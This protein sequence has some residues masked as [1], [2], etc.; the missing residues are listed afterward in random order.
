MAFDPNIV[1]WMF[2][3][4]AEHVKTLTPQYPLYLD[5]YSGTDQAWGEIRFDGPIIENY[6]YSSFR[7]DV[8]VNI[9]VTCFCGSDEYAIYRVAGAF[10][11]ALDNDICCFKYGNG[12]E[13]D[14]SMFV[15][16]QM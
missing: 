2:T 9:L 8:T 6:E 7:F 13:D 3:S 5:S 14:Q 11:T 12:P 15:T 1:R 10:A 16:L 4:V